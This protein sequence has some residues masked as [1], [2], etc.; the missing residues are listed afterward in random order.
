MG[1][2]PYEGDILLD[3]MCDLIDNNILSLPIH[4]ALYVEQKNIEAASIAIKKAWMQNLD[5]T[6]EPFVDID[7]P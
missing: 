6:F 4:D 7:Y 3:A 5:A 1:G 2:L